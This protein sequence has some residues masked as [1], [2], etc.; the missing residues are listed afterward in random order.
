MPVEL[1]GLTLTTLTKVRI[2]ERAAFVRHSVPGMEGDLSQNVGRPSVE[3]ELNGV[4]YGAEAA[5]N[6]GQLRDLY[7]QREPVDFFAAATGEGYFAQVLI[8][9]LE[10]VE[11]AGELDQFSYRCRLHEYVE[12]PEPVAAGGFPSLDT[13]LLDEAA[14]FIDDV[15]NAIEQVSQLVELLG[16][17][18]SFANPTTRLGALPTAF[19]GLADGMQGPLAETRVAI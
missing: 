8:S 1:G 9:N 6:L 16:N 15:Q 4:F 5:D 11:R 3:I 7:L 13:S 18:P 2:D 12:P 17:L 14:G 19:T 10:V